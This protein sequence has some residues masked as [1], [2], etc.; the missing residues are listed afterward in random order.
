M[1]MQRYPPGQSTAAS[2]P[3]VTDAIKS[4]IAA[5]LLDKRFYRDHLFI[6][7][8]VPIMAS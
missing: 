7:R 8:I 1:K 2:P 4:F 6:K 3:P 5:F